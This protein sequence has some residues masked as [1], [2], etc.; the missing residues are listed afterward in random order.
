MTPHER[1]SEI[2]AEPN[3]DTH[4]DYIVEIKGH[5]T[6][7]AAATSPAALALRYVPD[8]LVINPA[9]L[10]GYLRKLDE[11]SLT[12]LE[13][14]ATTILDD[15]N[16]EIVARWVQVRLTSPDDLHSGIQSHV[17]ILEDRQPGWNNQELLSRLQPF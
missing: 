9:S 3:P 5:V 16:N 14:I 8:R 1:R 13:S 17:V 11:L 12:T 7:P 6:L 10:G 4:H 2:S 15:I